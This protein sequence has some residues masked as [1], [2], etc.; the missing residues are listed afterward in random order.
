MYILFFFFKKKGG[1]ALNVHIPHF[2]NKK[3]SIY[4]LLALTK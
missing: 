3:D 1:G 2:D 4:A